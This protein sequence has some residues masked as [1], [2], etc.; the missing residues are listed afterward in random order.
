MKLKNNEQLILAGEMP[1]RAP[2]GEPLRAVPVYM[3]VPAE[4]KGTAITLA[5]NERLTLA[6]TTE[7][8]ITAEE[9]YKALLAGDTPPKSRATPLYIKEPANGANAATGL[10]AGEQRALNPLISDLIS[11][12]SAAMQ[13]IEM[14]KLEV[15]T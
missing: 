10:T 5:P 13:E 1:I 4:D 7:R 6:G 14:S 11:E 12:F 2:D 15:Q 3:I 8:K 9:R